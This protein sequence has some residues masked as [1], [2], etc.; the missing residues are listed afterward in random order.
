MGDTSSRMQRWS[1]HWAF[2]WAT[3]GAAIGLGNIWK[4]PYTL[5]DNGG[6]AFM[7]VYLI[8]VFVIGVPLMLAEA[9]IGKYGRRNAVDSLLNIANENKASR[10]WQCLGWWGLLALV[11]ILSFYSVVSGWS[12]AYLWR[13][14]A[15]YMQGLGNTQVEQMWGNFLADPWEMLLWHT[16]FMGMTLWVVARGVEGGLEKLNAYLM[17][18]LFAILILLVGYSAY[19]GE[20]MEAVKFLFAPDFSKIT[21]A[22]MLSALGQA[23][24]SLALGA[25][26]I[27][28][29]AAYSQESTSLTHSMSTI[30][31]LN[32]FVAILAGL[33]IFPIVF[34]YGLPVSEGPGLMYVVLPMAFAHMEYGMLVGALFFI[35][36]LF[37]AWTSSISLAE[38]VVYMLIER[39]RLTRKQATCLV[40]GFAWVLGIG[41]LLSFNVWADVKFAGFTI[42]DIATD[43]P[44]NIILPTG[45]L[46]FA[47]FVGWVIKRS[48]NEN[49]LQMR[50]AL[51]FKGWWFIVRYI[52]PLVIA[53]IFVTSLMSMWK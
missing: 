16:V 3:A 19:V 51:I 44:T 2:I 24:F 4:F 26:M 8:S 49:V 48:V 47:I 20:F 42:F 52:A 11:M 41:S 17:P 12:I 50:F 39:T 6:S 34:A 7:L 13:S 35:L 1:T 9:V 53:I 10:Y 22:V 25:G 37:A 36:L 30:A 14:A 27:T 43:V 15:G 33:A 18:G 28:V 46:L 23:F 21:P 31:I 45:G 5:G 29:Y 40:C 38:P 32:V